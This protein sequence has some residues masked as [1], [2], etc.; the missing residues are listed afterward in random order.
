MVETTAPQMKVIAIPT[1]IYDSADIDL[2][3]PNWMII[4][5]TIKENMKELTTT[6][7]AGIDKIVKPN[8]IAKAAPSAAPEATPKVRG[9]TNGFPKQP[10]IKEPAT[11]KAMP[12]TMAAS[13][14]G[15]L[16]S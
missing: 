12:P 8:T 7:N 11:A 9:E 16:Q 1:K 2:I 3:L 4:A 15:S 13:I 5:T 10:C 6:A 14:L